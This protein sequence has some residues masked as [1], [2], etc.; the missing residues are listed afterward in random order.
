LVPADI[1]NLNE[2]RPNYRCWDFLATKD[3][4]RYIV[5]VKFR[6]HTRHTGAEKRDVY[7]MFDSPAEVEEARRIPRDH[8]AIPAWI[9]GTVNA[10]RQTYCVYW[11]LFSEL[12]NW[13]AVPMSPDARRRYLALVLDRRDARIDPE[14]SNNRNVRSR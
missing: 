14:W 6:N 8:D 11:G 12:P 13:Q 1:V 3:G 10:P 7:N 9:T 2:I 5:Q 4:Q